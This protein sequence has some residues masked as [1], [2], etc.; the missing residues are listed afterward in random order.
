MFTKYF[1]KKKIKPIIRED[2]DVKEAKEFKE[3]LNKWKKGGKSD[4]T[5]RY[6]YKSVEEVIEKG[7]KSSYMLPEKIRCAFGKL[8]IRQKYFILIKK[9][10][11]IMLQR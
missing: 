1:N 7:K 10:I 8:Q 4:K 5:Q 11:S 6:Y 3:K 2:E 9:F